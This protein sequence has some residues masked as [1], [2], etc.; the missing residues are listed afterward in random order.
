[1]KRDASEFLDAW[2]SS[3]RREPLVIRGARQV[4]KTW[5]VRD[6]A[7]RHGLTLV[8]CN[9]ERR[10]HLARAFAVK[11][12]ARILV[13]LSFELDLEFDPARSL[14]FLDEIQAAGEVF[15]ELRWFAEERPEIPVVAAGSLLEFTLGDHE[16]SMPVGRI[17]YLHLEPMT[18][19]EYLTAHDQTRLRNEMFDWT[20]GERLSPALHE[21]LTSR[22]ERYLMVGGMPK[23]VLADVEG[24]DAREI[25]RVQTDLVTT[26][27][28]DFAKYTRKMDPGLLDT[29]LSAAVSMLGRK[30]VVSRAAENVRSEQ[31]RRALE[32]LAKA[33]L[34]HLVKMTATN[35]IPLG[36]EVNERYTKVI[37]NDVGLVNAILDTPA[38]ATFPP[39]ERIAPQIRGKL[40]EQVV[41]QALR[42]LREPFI[43]PRLFYWQRSGDRPGEVDYLLEADGRILPV[44]IKSGAAGS[45]KSLHQ[46]IYDKGLDLAV[47][48]DANPPTVQ[49]LDLS[50]GCFSIQLNLLYTF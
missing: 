5:L 32:L 46:F 22:L 17:G 28:D 33:R 9:F 25:R 19:P 23:V 41:G 40:T 16:F 35:G 11:N 10:P 34:V 42:T 3:D 14:I 31:A 2:L 13:E 49:D 50:T 7:K 37:L 36:G 6:L 29:L 39:W 47:R 8:E 12:P 30:F 26:F 38:K 4:G 1:M 43:E 15:A 24:S 45:M 27:R 21:R 20:L 48:L 18:F 44:E